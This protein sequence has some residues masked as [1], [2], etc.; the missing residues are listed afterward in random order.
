[1][2]FDSGEFGTDW[3]MTDW[4]WP[5]PRVPLK[6]GQKKKLSNL[7]GLNINFILF[8]QVLFLQDY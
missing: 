4:L 2:K 3:M 6:T 1:M 8:L 7:T 5:R